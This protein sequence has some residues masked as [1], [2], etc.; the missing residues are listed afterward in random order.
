MR[1]LVAEQRERR[2]K[3]QRQWIIDADEFRI[4]MLRFPD[5][6]ARYVD[7][8]AHLI[9]TGRGE[10]FGPPVDMIQVRLPSPWSWSVADFVRVYANKKGDRGRRRLQNIQA[11]LSR[12]RTS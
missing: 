8:V 3:S 9:E 6:D 2:E 11:K 4:S 12:S 10:F 5:L 1:F 7:S